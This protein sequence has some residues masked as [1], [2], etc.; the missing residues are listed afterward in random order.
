[1]DLFLKIADDLFLDDLYAKVVPAAA[2]ASSLNATLRHTAALSN[3]TAQF[4]IFASG[5]LSSTWSHLISYLPHPPLSDEL[6]HTST[7]A[8]IPATSAWPRDYI[9]RQVVSLTTLT[10][11]GIH[12]LYFVF[13]SLSYFFIFNHEMMKHP[14]F[15]KNQVKQEIICS[16]K[17]FPGMMLLT[18]P[19]FLGEVRGYSMLY[20][21]VEDFG[22]T[23]FFFSIFL[24]V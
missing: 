5:P 17:A 10:L 6:L 22:W 9:P 1:M 15:L 14:R 3:T 11:I 24:C 7:L 12:I 16:L 2:F 19:W 23:Y 21:N 13:A 20:E 18:L 8:S 4:P